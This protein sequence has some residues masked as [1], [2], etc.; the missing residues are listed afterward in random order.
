MNGVCLACGG[1]ALETVLDPGSMPAADWFPPV[2]QPLD[3]AEAAHPLA[4]V[5]CS[6][7]RLAQ[8]ASDD[9]VTEEPRGVEPLALREQAAEA[10]ARVAAAGL[11]RGSTVREF[12][13]PHGGSWS[14]LL[15]ARGFGVLGCDGGA[16]GGVA[17]VPADVVLDCFGLMHERDQRAAFARRVAATAAGGV[18]LV[19]YHPLHTIV[20]GDQWNALRHGHFAYYGL[21]FLR[22]R[23]AAAG[24]SVVRAWDFGLYGGT[25][26]IAAVHGPADPDASVAAVLGREAPARDARWVR[27][28]Q[29]AADR[30]CAQ[31]R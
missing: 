5:L 2:G 4:M 3:P 16:G 1:T 18:L 11:L 27:R 17:G 23:L 26:L 28:L 19:Q 31:L 9:T 30:Q 6:D 29:R 8:L 20:G 15:V 12:G 21:E 10:V 25:V 24:M 14:D 7:C 13:S 22:A